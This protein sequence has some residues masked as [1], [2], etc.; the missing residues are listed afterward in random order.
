MKKKTFF[1]FFRK[2]IATSFLIKTR[3]YSLIHRNTLT[4]FGI[5]YKEVKNQ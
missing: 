1:Y 3:V 4:G 5:T 2:L